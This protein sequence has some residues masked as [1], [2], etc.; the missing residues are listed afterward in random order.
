MLTVALLAAVP[1]HPAYA[2]VELP[3]G[4]DARVTRIV[5]GDTI[6]VVIQGIGFTIGYLGVD[7]PDPATA[8]VKAQCYSTQATA[9]NRSLVAGKTLRVER[10]ISDFDA[11]GRLLRYVYLPD[12]RLLNEVLLKGGYG[13]VTTT[14][15]DRKYQ[16]RFNAAQQAA[17]NGK[18]GLWGA[19]A[20]PAAVT[21]PTPAAATTGAC[22]VVDWAD[23]DK[24]GP[25]PAVLNPLPEG[26][27]V[28]VTPATPGMNKFSWHPA[29]SRV[30]LD[31]SMYL[32]WNDALI[33]LTRDNTGNYWVPMAIGGG[34]IE[35]QELKRGGDHGQMVLLPDDHTF[36]FEDWGS[37]VY[38]ALVD[39][40]QLE[41]G[42]LI[43][44]N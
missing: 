36:I 32:R 6:E 44:P 5:N 11:T 20:T 34:K 4:D 21:T 8:K 27:C 33:P 3:P 7:A 35:D 41:E 29:G 9:F 31:H 22:A 14:A 18:Q 25:R 12:G 23:L 28:I 43:I 42:K 37:G 26:A 17:Q 16:E 15:P 10:E 13:R 24:H 1:A 30:R 38:I 39:V 2:A 19:C 40:L